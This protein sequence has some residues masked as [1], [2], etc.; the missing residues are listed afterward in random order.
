MT[1][2][3]G[4]LFS[5][6]VLVILFSVKFYFETLKMHPVQTKQIAENVFVVKDDF[7]NENSKR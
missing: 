6:L 5:A 7:L 3:T 4:V 1:C 2:M